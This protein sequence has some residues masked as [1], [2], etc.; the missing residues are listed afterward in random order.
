ML[1]TVGELAAPWVAFTFWRTGKVAP[2]PHCRLCKAH[3]HL[4][5]LFPPHPTSWL[6]SGLREAT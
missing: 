6:G 2:G 3:S 5:F 4:L 1:A